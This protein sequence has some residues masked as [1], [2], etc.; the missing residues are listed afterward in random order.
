MGMLAINQTIEYNYKLTLLKAPCNLCL[1][2][3]PQLKLC[4]LGVANTPQ[5]N[6]SL[7]EKDLN[8]SM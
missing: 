8:T 1:E 4:M 6:Y 7:L 2:Q 5:F 3:K